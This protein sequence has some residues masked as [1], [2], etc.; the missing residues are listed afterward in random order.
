M[1]IKNI[2]EVTKPNMP[3]INN[4]I[5]THTQENINQATTSKHIKSKDTVNISAEATF[6]SKLNFEVK[7]YVNSAGDINGVSESRIN[8]LKQAYSGDNCPISSLDIAQSI[9]RAVCG[10]NL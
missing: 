1:D 10:C 5:V 8:D 2:Y 3:K 9:T 6:K 4:K 7:K